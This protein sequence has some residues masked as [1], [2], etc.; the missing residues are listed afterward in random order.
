M[1][2][3]QWFVSSYNFQ[4]KNVILRLFADLI[5]WP[6]ASFIRQCTMH[7]DSPE[8]QGSQP[9]PQMIIGKCMLQN[10]LRSV[11]NTE[12]WCPR[13]SLACQVHTGFDFGRGYH[14]P[15]F[16]TGSWNIWYIYIIYICIYLESPVWFHLGFVCNKFCIKAR[17]SVDPHF[18][19][20]HILKS[21]PL[22]LILLVTSV[23]FW[24]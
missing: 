4:T 16:C 12:T 17:F 7:F 6:A 21:T 10:K 20:I 1:S 19:L 8:M 15:V 14:A 18:L 11:Q 22:S 24:L 2:K 23:P 5:A 13:P 3:R 9:K